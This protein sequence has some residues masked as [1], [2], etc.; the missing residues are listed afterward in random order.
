MPIVCYNTLCVAMNK[1]ALSQFGVNKVKIKNRW[2]ARLCAPVL[3]LALAAGGALCAGAVGEGVPQ[4][5]LNAKSGVLRVMVSLGNGNYSM[6]TGFA[7]GTKDDMYV[8]TNHHVVDSGVHIYVYYDTGR[9]IEAE[10][11]AD[12]VSRDI[13]ILKPV[14][15]IPRAQLLPLQTDGV[16]DGIAVFALGYPGA[17]DI[18][19]EGFERGGY[20]TEAAFLAD[21]VA[22][23]PSMTITNGVVSAIRQSV[24]VGDA[25]REVK[26]IQTNTA[27]NQG[28]SGGPLLDAL[29]NVVGVNTLGISGLEWHI[30]SMNGAVHVDELITVLRGARIA[31]EG[32]V[33]QSDTSAAADD[34]VTP[35]VASPKG[36]DNT[37]LM[38]V[39]AG[40]GALVLGGGGLAAGLVAR[41]AKKPPLKNGVTLAD[42]EHSG[43]GVSEVEA[44]GMMRD[45]VARLLPLAQYDLNPLLSTSNVYIGDGTIALKERGAASDAQPGLYPGFSAPENY[46]MAAGSAATVYFLGALTYLLL[47]GE[48][49]PEAQ[50]RIRKNDPLYETADTLQAIVNQATE[51]YEQ[52]RIPN[53][54]RLY[55]ALMAG[56]GK[57]YAE[58]GFAPTGR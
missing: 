55:E 13:S 16:G 20:D 52:N 1:R 22:D 29:G 3:A 34:P 10:L 19:S 26:L 30:E 50:A 35:P 14:R 21:I 9:Y 24:L 27:I 17:A 58:N 53:L 31:Y 47:N 40:A 45:F 32:P 7:V 11:V 46:R 28:N 8:A 57:I 4:A 41:K 2:V 18:L 54:Q 48:R 43:R 44:Y 39:L 12:D 5:V 33:S 56:G 49:P 23:K 37:L 42:Y 25:S 15:N 6:G 38:I 36:D 51:P